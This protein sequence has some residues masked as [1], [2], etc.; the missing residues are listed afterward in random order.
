MNW[1]QITCMSTPMPQTPG[2]SCHIG[3]FSG[4]AFQSSS[5]ECHFEQ[6]S[7]SSLKTQYV[8]YFPPPL[9][10]WG[11]IL[12]LIN[13]LAIRKF[14]LKFLS[15]NYKSYFSNKELKN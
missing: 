6:G 4:T 10:Q 9:N 5:S 14:P 1:Q 7:S 13:R 3:I 12:Y 8:H 15:A 11:C 2:F